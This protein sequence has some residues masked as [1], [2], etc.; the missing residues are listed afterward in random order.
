MKHKYN[1]FYKI[2]N[3]I[4]NHFYYGIHS[5]DNLDDGYMGSGT[6]LNMAYKK[7]GMDNF[8]K[9]ILKY[10][11][12]RKEAAEYEEEMVTESLILDDNCYNIIKGGENFDLNG[13][14]IAF[15]IEEK[16]HVAVPK[17]IYD[18][19]KEIRYFNLCKNTVVVFDKISNKNVRISS[20]EFLTNKDKY[21]AICKNKVTVKDKNGKYY[22]VSTDDERY[23]NG[24][25]TYYWKGR[26]HSPETI[27]KIKERHKRTKF[28]Q[29]EKNSQYG[30]CW[31][32][33]DNKNKKIQKE[34]LNDYINKGWNK[35]RKIYDKYTE[36]DAK[37]IK[38]LR[39]KD[40]NWN[41]ISAETNIPR[42]C[43]LKLRRKYN[44][45]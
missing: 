38:E 33:K 1:Y 7:Y 5:T 25:L 44:I 21:A 20:E 17:T 16:R 18:K 29:G 12:T 34:D 14:V 30:T 43:I 28:Q 27:E 3:N 23:L 22:H 15:D 36:D 45:Q 4:N 37:R 39:N 11:E 6:R 2:T 31:I 19:L 10:F 32:T 42:T 40:L 13:I 9:E 41:Q 8:T 24:E 35:G 26:K